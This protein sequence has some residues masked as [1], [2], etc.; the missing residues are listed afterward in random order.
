MKIVNLDLK[1]QEISPQGLV[2]DLA[3]NAELKALLNKLYTE[4]SNEKEKAQK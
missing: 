2:I 3:K 4:A 1:G